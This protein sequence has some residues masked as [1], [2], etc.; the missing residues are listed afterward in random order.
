[1]GARGQAE[2]N[3]ILEAGLTQAGILLQQRVQLVTP[4]LTG[5]L[6]RSIGFRVDTHAAE[7][8]IGTLHEE[9]G[10]P[11]EYAHYVE[12]GTRFMEGRHFF[13]PTVEA[14]IPDAIREIEAQM[15]QGLRGVLGD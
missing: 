11:V 12:F 2:L 3:N 15:E 7:L 10:S 6:R 1:M 9:G 13:F 14:S 8:M 5:I 4:V